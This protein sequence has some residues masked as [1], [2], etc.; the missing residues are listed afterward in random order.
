VRIE[1]ERLVLRRWT[2]DDVGPLS[3][4]LLAPAVA[5]W[6]GH[7]SWDDVER[8]LAHYEHSWDTLGFGRF[9]VEERSTGRLVGRV[10]VMRQEGW[11]A[12]PDSDEVGWAIVADCWG[13]GYATEAARAAITDGFER[14]GLRRILSW[15]LPDNDASRRVMEK[16]GLTLGGTAEWAGREHLWYAIDRA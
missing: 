3:E 7:P 15:T 4:I 8:T 2:Q 16:C 5:A 12:T 14:V 9:A 1:T 6:L 13:R 10:A 11:V